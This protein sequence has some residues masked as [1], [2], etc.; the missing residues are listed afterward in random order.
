MANE[1]INIRLS[2]DDQA[3]AKLKNVRNNIDGVSASAKI[4]SQQARN[5][6][7]SLGGVGRGAG[8]AG[9]QVQQFVGQIQGGVNPMV[10]LSQQ[11]TDLGFVLGVPLVGAIVGISA[12]IA[13]A[14]LP[15]LLA[16][17]KSFAD[18]AKEVKAVG[19]DLEDLPTE[20]I[21]AE[22]HRLTE[23]M[24]D[25]K[26]ALNSQNEAVRK[27]KERLTEQENILRRVGLSEEDVANQTL[28]LRS[29]VDRLSESIPQ[30][31]S[32]LI[33]STARLKNFAGE[34]RGA[35][36]EIKTFTYETDRF[37]RQTRKNLYNLPPVVLDTDPITS[38][39][40]KIWQETDKTTTSFHRLGEQV[41]MTAM[42]LDDV[43]RS[44]LQSMEDGLVDLING[45]KSASEAFSNMARSIIN[46][47]IRMYIQRQITAP[48][49]NAMFGA[50]AT[51]YTTVS[52]SANPTV[53]NPDV[54]FEGGGYTGRGS[55]SGGVDGK[56][57]F[58][59]ILHPNETVI[60]HTKGQGMDAPV[61]INLNVST[62]VSQTVRTE[63]MEMM[64][65]IQEMAKSAVATARMRGGAYGGAM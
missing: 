30:L 28:G 10:A 40:S 39:I 2:A 45:T 33:I 38:D 63:L 52:G 56:G 34:F 12:S 58:N 51:T 15:S 53:G 11:A 24:N 64:P 16:A 27:A 42:N 36:A 35:S 29:E 41:K 65:R 5:L 19:L 57:G 3:S 23:A 43:G 4:T 60:D 14:L 32:D 46:D 9:I 8:Q 6:G 59:A 54:Y 61:T 17:S 1:N 7:G 26:D 48:L 44:G 22:T 50:S 20:V 55:R 37:V 62:G 21:I 13:A 47:L 49:F 18:L 31:T 25:A